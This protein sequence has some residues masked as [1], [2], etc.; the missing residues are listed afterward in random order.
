M[1]HKVVLL[2]GIHM[3]AWSLLPFAHLLKSCDV[4]ARTFGYYSVMG[5]FDDHVCALAEW[6]QRFYEEDEG[7]LHFVGHSLGGLVLRYFAAAYPQWVTGK[8]VTLGTP[9]QGSMAAEKLNNLMPFVLGKA[10]DHALDG[11]LPPLPETVCLGSIAGCKPL[12]LG[13]VLGLPGDNDGT[14][15]VA[16]TCV[17]GMRDHIVLPVTHTGMLVDHA[18]ARQTAYFLQHGRFNHA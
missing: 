3:H 5:C 18:V 8:I 1:R 9:H 12:G 4:E 11:C 10:Y 17:E 14:V 7:P 13:R 2:H 6:V 16:E 15:T